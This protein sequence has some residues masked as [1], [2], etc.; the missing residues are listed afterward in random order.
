MVS[1]ETLDA[2]SVVDQLLV[3]WIELEYWRDYVADGDQLLFTAPQ[4]GPQQ[5]EIHEF[6]R[7]DLRLFD[8]SDATSP[9]WISGQIAEEEDGQYQL[10]FEDAAQTNSRF[11]ALS[12]TVFRA[13][14]SVTL[15]QPTSWKS[16]ENGADHIIITH[17]DFYIPRGCWPITDARRVC[18]WRP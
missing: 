5:F 18:V 12:T 14:V 9:V 16:T 10:L 7:H 2:D 4:P 15:D 11:L 6:T 17:G 8:I 1:V 13:P 3:N